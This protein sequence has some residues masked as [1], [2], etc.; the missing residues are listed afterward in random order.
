MIAV[1]KDEFHAEVQGQFAT[2][3]A[4]LI[5]LRRR[6]DAPWDQS[7]NLCPCTCWE[8]C[9]RDL[10]VIEYDD[11]VKPWKQLHRWGCLEISCNGALWYGDFRNGRIQLC[12]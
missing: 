7:P 12:A 9:H 1:I 11:S 8:T 5:E 6:A 3:E 10:V 2:V 4:A